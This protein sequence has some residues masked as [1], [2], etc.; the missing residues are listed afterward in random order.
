MS[1]PA[2]KQRS[3][4][5]TVTTTEPVKHYLESLV[6]LGAPFLDEEKI[7]ILV[8]EIMRLIG[9]AIYGAASKA[10]RMIV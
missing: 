4:R 6:Q 3:I 9:T 8:H 7:Q 1:R 10:G 5:I 2:N